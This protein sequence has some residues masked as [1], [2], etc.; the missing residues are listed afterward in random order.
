VR[1]RL[2]H[3][4]MKCLACAFS[5]SHI[6]RSHMKMSEERREWDAFEA[7]ARS[8]ASMADAK[9]VAAGGDV[10][11]RCA[12]V[13]CAHCA[14]CGGDAARVW[15]RG[16]GDSPATLARRA[17]LRGEKSAMSR[18]SSVRWE[19]DS[20]N[21]IE[22]AC[23]PLPGPCARCIRREEDAKMASEP[24][25]SGTC[26]CCA[27][28]SPRLMSVSPSCFECVSCFTSRKHIE[29]TK[30]KM[31]G[32]TG[33]AIFILVCDNCHR[34]VR[35]VTARSAMEVTRDTRDTTAF[36]I[37]GVQCWRSASLPTLVEGNGDFAIMRSHLRTCGSCAPPS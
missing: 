28:H 26:S 27:A 22:V 3:H 37:R 14:A 10:F 23:D 6:Q 36:A 33:G 15:F 12:V 30:I 13:L 29:R 5:L 19:V 31:R 20:M 17:G 9:T 32:Y 16:D 18:L 24:R 4:R 21:C 11:V 2:I 35:K 7:M 8:A 34:D 25:R 1:E